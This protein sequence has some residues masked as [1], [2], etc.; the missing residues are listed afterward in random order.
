MPEV[1]LDSTKF[2]EQGYCVFKNVLTPEEIAPY[3]SSLEGMIVDLPEGRRPE[4]LVEPQI[5]ASDWREWLELIRH[6]KVIE[7]A[8]ESLQT[9]E[10]IV[11]GSHLIVKPAGDGLAIRWHQDNTYWPSVTGTEVATAWIAFDKADCEN[12]CM[13]VIPKSHSGF[14][15]LE[16]IPTDGKDLLGV[17]VEVTSEMEASQVPI[18]LGVG[19]V[20]FHDSFIIHGSEA[21]LSERRRAGYVIRFCDAS[22]VEVD[23]EKHG[24]PVYYVSGQLPR[25]EWRDIR[26]GKDL[27]AGP[28][29]HRS[30]RFENL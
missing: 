13:N 17:E 26:I 15:E 6:P 8:K 25:G 29:E 9:D 1:N 7:A 20:S 24:K 22:K 16:M 12:A 30:K 28:G 14:Q 4:S 10:L 27:P 23:V 18:E 5:R 19:D 11:L 3:V 2:S 21:N